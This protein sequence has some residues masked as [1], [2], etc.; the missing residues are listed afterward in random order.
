MQI[1]K[2]EI[3]GY[4]S[5]SNTMSLRDELVENERAVLQ[6]G[7]GRRV[8]LSRAGYK[9]YP[10]PCASLRVTWVIDARRVGTYVGA[11]FR[12]SVMARRRRARAR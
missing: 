11:H 1:L 10:D 8:E 12:R 7:A 9:V 4:I 6:R 2:V 5:L 3:T